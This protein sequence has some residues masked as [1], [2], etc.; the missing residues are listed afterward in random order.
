MDPIVIILLVLISF[1]ILVFFF[2]KP[3]GRYH[4]H[5]S[6]CNRSFKE[7]GELIEHLK[8]EHD[9]DN[10]LISEMLNEMDLQ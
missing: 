10:Q 7:L 2:I 9:F 6:G 5:I 8:D 4:C 1:P 3:N